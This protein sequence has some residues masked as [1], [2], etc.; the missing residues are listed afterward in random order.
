MKINNIPNFTIGDKVIYVSDARSMMIGKS[1]VVISIDDND[2][3]CVNVDFGN[4]GSYS[5]F[6]GNL[7]KL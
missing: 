3:Y 7:D 6:R 5:C 4:Y 1:G 2:I